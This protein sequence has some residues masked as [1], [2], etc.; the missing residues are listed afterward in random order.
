MKSFTVGGVTVSP[1]G[2]RKIR[3]ANG[4]PNVRIAIFKRGGHSNIHFFNLPHPMTKEEAVAYVN[5]LD[6]VYP[7]APAQGQRGR[8]KKATVKS[9]PISF[10]N[11]SEITG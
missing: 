5:S 2:G 3:V 10:D 11:V 1:N 4:N 6:G 8:P 7:E 9:E